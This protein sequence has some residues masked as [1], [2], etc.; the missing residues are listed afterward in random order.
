[1]EIH[2]S[3]ALLYLI[4]VL[5]A[6]S[7]VAFGLERVGRRAP[8]VFSGAILLSAC[9]AAAASGDL[10]G[11][12]FLLAEVP[13][14]GSISLFADGISSSLLLA[15]LAVAGLVAISCGRTECGEEQRGFQA[16]FLLYVAGLAGL[17]VSANLLLLFAFLELSLIA[18]WLMLGWWG[19]P[20]RGRASIKYFIYTE[21]GA[22]LLL[23]GILLLWGSIGTLD[24]LSVSSSAAF[25]PGAMLATAFVIAGVF[26]K[27]AVIPAHG[28]LPD[29]YSESPPKLAAMMS[30][31]TVVVGAYLLLRVFGSYIPGALEGQGLSL[32]LAAFGLLNISY[33]GIAAIREN[34]LRRILSYSS[35]SQAG[36]V[37]I[38]VASASQVGFLGVLIWAVAHGFGK[39]ALF[40]IS[41]AYRRL[42][43]TDSLED[44]GGLAGRMPLTSSSLLVSFL[45]LAGIPPT[46]GFWGEFFILYGFASS[47]LSA[48]LDPFGLGIFVVAAVFTVV[49]AAYGLWTVRRALYGAAG[50]AAQSA[51]ENASAAMPILAMVLVLIVLGLMPFLLTEAYW[52]FPRWP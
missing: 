49:S 21:L 15:L 43:G 42:L 5:L 22:L 16:L 27:S 47:L 38:G 44:L 34:D 41:G 1:M 31:S 35:I 7:P 18:S 25:P 11:S 19:G 39:P 2:G 6:S 10:N 48:G 13:P 20:G 17:F 33:G 40:L 28:W 37:L 36:Y 26:V 29:A 24:V 51:R 30:F 23:T 50:H 8:A 14:L 9:L 32:A 46:L 12:F 52:I 4:T 45:S 3:P